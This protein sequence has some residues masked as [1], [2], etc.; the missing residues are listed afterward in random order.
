MFPILGAVTFVVALGIYGAI[1]YV[2]VAAIQR[3]WPSPWAAFAIG[4]GG[5][6]GIIMVVLALLPF[7]GESF[8][9]GAAE[10]AY[11]SALLLGALSGSLLGMWAIGRKA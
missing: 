10:N 5:G 2:I 9:S 1:G 11:L 6:G 8:S 3:R 7:V 4:A